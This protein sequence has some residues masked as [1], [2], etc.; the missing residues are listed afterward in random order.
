MR[1]RWEDVVGG[2]VGDLGE[3]V[4]GDVVG[5][6]VGDLGEKVMEVGG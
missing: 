3:K 4:M 1:R 6:W 5:G 2:W